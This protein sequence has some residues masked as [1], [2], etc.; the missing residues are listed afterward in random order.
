MT[1]CLCLTRKEH[2]E[3]FLDKNLT[4]LVA[5]LVQIGQI[6]EDLNLGPRYSKVIHVITLLMLNRVC[7]TFIMR[8]HRFLMSRLVPCHII[9][10][11]SV[12]A[13]VYCYFALI[14]VQNI[15]KIFRQVINKWFDT[16]L[17]GLLGNRYG[18]T[19]T[20]F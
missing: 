13:D 1:L 7:R 9:I 15:R 19:T 5:L 18:Y 6:D 3:A 14:E 10:T 8:R 2:G 11:T 20:Y 4:F 16:T 17:G 12:V